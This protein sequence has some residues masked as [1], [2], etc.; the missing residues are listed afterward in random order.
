MKKLIILVVALVALLAIWYWMSGSDEMTGGGKAPEFATE[1][2]TLSV[3]KLVV[4][5][6]GQPDI[7]MNQGSG[8]IWMLT[9]P[10]AQRANQNMA[11]QL[12]RGLSMMALKDRV[13]SRPEMQSNFQVD[14]LQASR[15][16]AFHGETMVADMYVGKLATDMIHVYARRAGSDDVYMATGGSA[17]AAFRTRQLNDFRDHSILNLD[18]ALIDSVHIVTLQH[19]YT[20][21]HAD[22]ISWQARIGRKGY[23]PAERAVTEGV[24]RGLVSMRASGFADDSTT[25][26]WS[27]PVARVSLWSLGRDP[28]E[29]SMQPVVGGKDYWVNVDGHAYVYKVFESTFKSLDRDPAALFVAP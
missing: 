11:I 17:M 23:Q 22:T 20:I 24:L 10:L 29:M 9:E 15:L 7:V 13:S 4:K 3:T 28:V 1:A 18:L 19:D 2:D 6:W 26:D 25:I 14:E 27:K 21:A 16:Q 5:R 8:G 12:V